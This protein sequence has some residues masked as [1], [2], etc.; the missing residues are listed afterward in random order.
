[1]DTAFAI[2]I[3]L[4]SVV[5]VVVVGIAFIWA[6]RKDGEEDRALQKR[7]GIRRKTRLGP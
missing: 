2:L 7:L 6:A 3:V 1:M 4:V 5:S